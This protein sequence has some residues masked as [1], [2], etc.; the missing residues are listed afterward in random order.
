MTILKKYK[1]GEIIPRL[2]AAFMVVLLYSLLKTSESFTEISFYNEINFVVFLL[3]VIVLFLILCIVK[4]NTAINVT[5]IFLTL[6]YFICAASMKREYYFSIG[7]CAVMCIL[8]AF[9][10]FDG[11]KLKLKNKSVRLAVALFIIAFT[12]FVGFICC[13]Y[14]KNYKTP[15]YDFG[16][17]SQMFWY[18]KETGEC[19]I[20]CERDTLLNHF[21]VHFSPIYY[22]I[23]PIYIIIP[24]PCTLLVLQALI[25]ASG[26]IPLS[27]ISKHYNL[28]ALG[29]I[30]FSVCYILYPG[31]MGGCF[32]Y[33]H[34]NCFL[35]PLL[36]WY[37]YFS[38]KEKIFPTVFFAL[39]TLTVKE[40]A[41]VYV[42][43][44]A[45][46]FIF[47]RK[48]YKCN[49]FILFFSVLY[50]VTVTKL[51]SVYGEGVMSD[52]R[53][54]EYIYDD[55]GLF[56]VIKSVIQNPIFAI[57]QIFKEEKFLFIL[58]MLCPLGFLP[59]LI[60]KPEKLILFIPLILVNLM[61]NYPYQYDIGFQYTFGSGAILFY[62]SVT[63]Y[64]ESGKNRSKILLCGVL[65][66]VII[67][68]G[69]YLSKI[70]YVEEYISASQQREVIDE[71][72]KLVPEDAS[73]AASTRLVA[74]LSEREVIYELET[75]K[76]NAEYIVFD[77]RNSEEKSNLEKYLNDRYTIL[78]YEEE[79]ICVFKNNK[80][81]C[82][83][84]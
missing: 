83:Q 62:L 31:F 43:L 9:F 81:I 12:L 30:L 8:V 47:S 46:Y 4:N 48:N 11:I 39:L 49:L 53:Y 37:L 66:A 50:F 27:L 69:G 25:V 80:L 76:Q 45:S 55:S 60:K 54:G 2:T 41:A 82:S 40:D 19:L 84:D 63:N 22:L 6:L 28:S 5:A 42:A 74:N 16:L 57:Y 23:L 61:T 67:F 17:F 58:Q 68:S 77:L 59:L 7:L 21:A 71:A 32:W 79:I 73:V 70:T 15:C 13:L 34:E 56:S 18:M 1:I 3:C 29:T 35:L 10:N 52:S 44:I 33:L 78:F 65:S 38:E 64:S 36:L 20:T 24:S 14:Y 75:T 26:L 51:M 72:L